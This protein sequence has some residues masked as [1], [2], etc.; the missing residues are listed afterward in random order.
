[1]PAQ[2]CCGR[3]FPRPLQLYGH[4]FAQSCPRSEV[5]CAADPLLP[6][7]QSVP[8][9]PLNCHKHSHQVRNSTE[10]RVSGTLQA[11]PP[12]P[13]LHPCHRGRGT[14]RRKRSL[15]DTCAPCVTDPQG[16]RQPPRMQT[17]PCLPPPGPLCTK[18]GWGTWW[19][20]RT[21]RLL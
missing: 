17:G 14:D 6:G 16:P 15:S 21:R 10:G 18:P 1:M 8:S 9:P 12:E 11:Q 2:R 7:A 3:S 4:P 13:A 20:R 19:E 5:T